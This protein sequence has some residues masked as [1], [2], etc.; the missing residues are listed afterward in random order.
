MSSKKLHQC[1]GSMPGRSALCP[2]VTSVL[3]KP[4]TPGAESQWPQGAAKLF[5]WVF[6]TVLQ[7]LS[8]SSNKPCLEERALLS[9]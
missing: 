6:L 5:T 7:R 2:V 4:E 3:L 9:F 8:S 1:V